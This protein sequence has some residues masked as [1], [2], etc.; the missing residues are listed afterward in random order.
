VFQHL[1]AG[2]V[3]PEETAIA[4]QKLGKHVSAVTNTCT[5]VEELL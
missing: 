1:K 3:E 4:R 2:I 5:T